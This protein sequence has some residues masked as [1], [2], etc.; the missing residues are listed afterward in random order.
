MR[1]D[2]SDSGVLGGHVGHDSLLARQPGA[3]HLVEDSRSKTHGQPQPSPEVMPMRTLRRLV[4]GRAHPS[5][6][7]AVA[8]T[9]VVVTATSAVVTLPT[10]ASAQDS[11]GADAEALNLALGSLEFREIGPAIMGGRVADI[12]AVEG[13]SS[14]FYVGFATGGLWK[15][16][17]Q[18]MTFEPLFDHQPVSSIGEVT[19]AP[20]NPNVIWV[21]TG[22]PQNRQ[23]SPYGNGIYRSV[24]GGRTW[25]HEI[26]RAHV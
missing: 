14:I 5:M 22:E 26:G 20:S 10:A 13:N 3:L 25:L 8:L 11:G 15:T 21:G 9:L 2:G 4:A 7:L 23:S 17:N 16:T 18:G 24:D 19:I 1:T 6:P 12:A